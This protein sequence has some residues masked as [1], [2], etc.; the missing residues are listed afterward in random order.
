[1]LRSRRREAWRCIPRR[2]SLRV[3]R[4]PGDWATAAGM[5]P[6]VADMRHRR[7]TAPAGVGIAGIE[8]TA[9]CARGQRGGRKAAPHRFSEGSPCFFEP[10]RNALELFSLKFVEDETQANTVSTGY[11]P[12]SAAASVG[13]RDFLQRSS[14]ARRT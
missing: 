8:I 13:L 7:G 4:V 5:W 1:M 6:A 10:Q 14:H 11:V 3:L 9:M 12:V 2:R